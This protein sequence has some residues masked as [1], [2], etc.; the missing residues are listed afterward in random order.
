[1]LRKGRDEWR[2]PFMPPGCYVSKSCFSLEHKFSNQRLQH[3][4]SG[5]ILL[6]HN[7]NLSLKPQGNL[8]QILAFISEES[9]LTCENNALDGT[10]IMLT[11]TYTFISYLMLIFTLNLNP[12]AFWKGTI[13]LLWKCFSATC[14]FWWD[15]MKSQ[16]SSLQFSLQTSILIFSLW[17]MG[18]FLTCKALCFG[19]FESNM[20]QTQ[21]H[22]RPTKY[23]SPSLLPL[24]GGKEGIKVE[25][26][27]KSIQSS[28]NLYLI[29]VL[30]LRRNQIKLSPSSNH[31]IRMHWKTWFGW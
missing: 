26:S 24:R 30:S 22:D 2:I 8:N 25:A 19:N 28:C 17:T 13:F 15:M 10:Y 23:F 9:S 29:K 16:Y 12:L 14:G 3:M 21:K 18:S 4:T 31:C 1:M 5:P 11:H 27:G 6:L 7:F 20:I